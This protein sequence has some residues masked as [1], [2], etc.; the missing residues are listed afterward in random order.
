MTFPVS[1]EDFIAHQEAL[2][3]RN[4][5]PAERK[6]VAT[7]VPLIND[8]YLNGL[9]AEDIAKIDSLINRRPK[10]SLTRNFLEAAKLWM[11]LADKQRQG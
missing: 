1:V 7:W 4:L 8:V 5:A 11:I 9:R 3:H 10:A 2:I 6:L